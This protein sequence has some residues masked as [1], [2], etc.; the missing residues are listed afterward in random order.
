MNDN[1]LGVWFGNRRV[2]QLRRGPSRTMKFQYEPAWAQGN[3]FAISQSMP[4]DGGDS[5]AN[6]ERA[7]HFFANL[8]PE[9]NARDHI[10]RMYRVPDDD[11]DLLRAFGR[12]CAGALVILPEDQDPDATG[13]QDYDHASDEVLS[14]LLYEHGWNFEDSRGDLAP[15]LSL[16]G[17][18]NKTSVALLD[19]RICLPKGTSPSTH[20][21]KFDSLAYSNVLTYECFA[22]MLAGSAGLPVVEFEL[23]KSGHNCF[24]L[25]KRYDRVP[26]DDRRILRLHQEDFCQALGYSSRMKYET[27]GGPTFA[28]CY[29]L[30][31]DVSDAPLDDLESL[32][33]WQIFNVMAGNSD[34]HP[35]N[36][37][38]LYG[39]DGST[40]LAPFYDLVPT[41]AIAHLDQRL[42]LSVGSM[43][44]P[45]NVSRD[46]WEFLAA[47]CGVTSRVV[48][49]LVEGIA[50]SL[51]A[52]THQIRERFEELH[53]PS[54]ALDRV[55]S[56]VRRQCRNAIRAVGEA[57]P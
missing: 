54:P 39:T 5:A 35:K 24:A 48:V 17:A 16:A 6:D 57:I 23:R 18:Q 1:V 26:G 34:G 37:S 22:T 42:A 56:I 47:E 20:I 27:D 28:R 51:T 50:E 29:E 31:R 46:H 12:E 38:L 43:R 19:G 45:G 13:S 2:G 11:F 41:R 8:L 36:L 25:I 21:L 33:R 9:G 15:R 55:E 52:N 30:V 40:R 14:E 7:H 4:L 32:L 49:V 53:G 3:G 10:V 44:H